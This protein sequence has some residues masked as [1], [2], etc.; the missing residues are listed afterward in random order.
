MILLF[1]YPRH[2]GPPPEKIFGPLNTSES[3]ALRG[4]FHTS[5]QGIFGGFWKTRVSIVS[6]AR[7]TQTQA[8]KSRGCLLATLIVVAE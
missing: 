3:K 5:S 2:P 8:G 4:S 1:T 7:N 6:V